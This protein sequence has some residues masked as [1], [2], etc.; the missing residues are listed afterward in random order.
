MEHHQGTFHQLEQIRALNKP[1]Q[2]SHQ[3]HYISAEKIT[4]NTKEHLRTYLPKLII[5]VRASFKCIEKNY[6]Q[7]NAKKAGNNA[8]TGMSIIIRQ[9]FQVAL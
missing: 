6:K 7:T 9:R 4:Q 1:P 5:F 2:H 8:L 3:S